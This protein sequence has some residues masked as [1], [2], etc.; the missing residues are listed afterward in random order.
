MTQK[1]YELATTIRVRYSETDKMGIVYNANYFD[2]FEVARTEMCRAWGVSYTEWEKDGLLLPVV[3]SHC[4]YKHPAFYDDRIGLW[5]RVA[6]LKVHS[7]T[8]EYRLLREEDGK[9]IAEGWTKHGC[10]DAAG[11]LYKKEHPFYLWMKSCGEKDA[12]DA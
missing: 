6:E 11:K 2:W 4:R 9:L 8:F 12:S 10:T 7:V 5:C 1:N 3:E